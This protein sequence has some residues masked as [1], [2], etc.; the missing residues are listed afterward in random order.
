MILTLEDFF[1]EAFSFVQEPRAN[2][3]RH[4]LVD[5]LVIALCSVI[6]GAEGWDE[7][8]WFGREQEDWFESFL[9]LPFGI[10]S[11]STFERVISSI[12]PDEFCQSLQWVTEAMHAGRL[13]ALNTAERREQIAID[14]KTLRKSFDTA[15]GI[16]AVHTVNAY[17]CELGACIGQVSVSEKSNEITAI[18]RLIEILELRGKIVSI[19]AMGTQKEIAK[20][21]RSKKA[22]YVLALKKNHGDLFRAVEELFSEVD[23]LTTLGE[24]VTTSTTEKGHGRIEKRDVAVVPFRKLWASTNQWPDLAT[25]VAVDSVR[26]INGAANKERRFYITSLPAVPSLAAQTIRNHWHVENKLHWT[27]DVTFREDFSRVRKD[28]GPK[29]LSILRKITLNLLKADKKQK[30]SIKRKRLKAAMKTDYLESLF[31]FI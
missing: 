5:I 8:A 15:S 11:A 1:E 27:L 31:D 30:I 14:G 7:I 21:I 22:D 13:Q 4:R 6:C 24:E 19:D 28:H 12:C 26:E 18:P 2:Q 16:K 10:P 17:A 25:F 20:D 9:E 29:N 23:D 3:R